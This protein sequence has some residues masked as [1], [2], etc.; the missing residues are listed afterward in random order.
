MFHN[1]LS[2]RAGAH[3]SARFVTGTAKAGPEEVCDLLAGACIVAP[4]GEILAQVSTNSDEVI[5]AAHRRI[6]HY[7]LI[8]TRT[9]ATPPG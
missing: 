9:G 7:R 6:E 1:H 2:V 8:A 5:V 4:S 3:R